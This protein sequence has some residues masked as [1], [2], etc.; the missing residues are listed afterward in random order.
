MFTL[1]PFV[2]LLLILIDIDIMEGLYLVMFCLAV[3]LMAYAFRSVE[4]FRNKRVRI[5]LHGMYL[6]AP[7]GDQ[8]SSSSRKPFQKLYYLSQDSPEHAVPCR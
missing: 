2:I 7:S 5:D 3:T 8:Q 6:H 4:V 1:K